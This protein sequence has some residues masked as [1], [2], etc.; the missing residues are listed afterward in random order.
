MRAV[1]QRPA[2]LHRDLPE[3][4]LAQLVE[5]LLDEVGLADRDAARGDDDV[6][7]GGGGRERALERF[8]LVAHDAH[9]DDVA[10]EA[11]QHPVERVAVAV[12]DLAFGSVASRP[13]GARRRW[14]R[15][16]RAASG[17]P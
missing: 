16:R 1:R 7:R 10:I 4:H 12:V 6:G 13:S 8:R 2:R 9:V 11:R 3:Q 15:T 5:L 17:R 14:K